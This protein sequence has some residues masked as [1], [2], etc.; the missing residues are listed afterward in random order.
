MSV[1]SAVVN[2]RDFEALARARLDPASFDYYAGGAGDERTLAENEAAF[3]R[4]TFCPRVL[5]GTEHVDTSTE[6]F[7][8]RVAVPVLLA[9]TA[10]NCLGHP[11]GELAVVR[12]AGA[13][14]T[15]MC[16]STASSQTLEDIAATA[17]GP[18]WFQLYIYRDRAITTDLVRRAETSGYRALVLTVDT[19]RLGRRE[20]DV[21]NHF[22]LP[23]GVALRNLD[24]YGQSE[25]TRW[26][27]QSS[28]T[29]YVHRM[30]DPSV[31]WEALTWLRSVTALPVVIKGILSP[32]DSSLAVEYGAA[33]IIVSNHGGRQLD[34]AVA[35]I[36]ALPRVI[37][38][39]D[40][41]IPVLVDGGVR[42]GIDVLAALALGA[43]AVLIGRP[44]LWALAV[45]GETGV[46]QVLEFL[47]AELELAMALTGC[48]RVS[49]IGRDLIVGV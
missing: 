23:A 1:K 36:E 30:F 10:F 26:S 4:L 16:C 22:V 45:G 8:C 20:R 40:G 48:A 13:A 24:R 46:C 35:T 5:A 19:P 34:G 2:V 44:Y 18:L 39:V 42:R 27:E 32:V 41:R 6:L 37:S 47:R 33:G 11:D 3:R 21:R 17:T 12:A 43:R 29:Q 31:T 38:A 7:G 9:P 15:I 49:A 25:A 14:G 28:F